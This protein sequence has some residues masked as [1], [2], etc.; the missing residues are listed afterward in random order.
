MRRAT[1]FNRMFPSKRPMVVPGSNTP[2]EN[3]FLHK[4]ANSLVQKV[5]PSLTSEPGYTSPAES[6]APSP[7]LSATPALRRASRLARAGQFEKA[8]EALPPAAETPNLS[9]G[10]RHAALLSLYRDHLI[11]QARKV[12]FKQAEEADF[13][14]IK[15]IGSVPEFTKIPT[16]VDEA[17]AKLPTIT[18]DALLV[19]VETHTSFSQPTSSVELFER[20]RGLGKLPAQ[21]LSALATSIISSSSKL[22]AHSQVSLAKKVLLSMAKEPVV[23]PDADTFNAV[24][25]VCATNVEH[26]LQTIIETIREMQH[27]G[28]A[29]TMETVATLVS[30]AEKLPVSK[31]KGL[32]FAEI[33]K[34]YTGV[35]TAHAAE[36]A[37][38][39]IIVSLAQLGFV[40]GQTNTSREMLALLSGDKKELSDNELWEQLL[41]AVPKYGLDVASLDSVFVKIPFPVRVSR[42]TFDQVYA[43]AATTLDKASFVYFCLWRIHDDRS[44]IE[45]LLT[46]LLDT[47]AVQ[48]KENGED[49]NVRQAAV[50]LASFYMKQVMRKGPQKQYLSIEPSSAAVNTILWALSDSRQTVIAWRLIDAAKKTGVAV[51]SAAIVNFLY[52]CIKRK[53]SVGVVA[54]LKMLKNSKEGFPRFSVQFKSRVQELIA[55]KE[56]AAFF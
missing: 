36:P 23:A 11:D 14:G 43:S 20:F 54:G 50:T 52:A 25:K 51:D 1:E 19:S 38:Q 8:V 46:S 33:L 5:F 42:K 24:L 48:S 34:A 45:D 15:G 18:L 12:D 47:I 29:G 53:D 31:T 6:P 56:Y 4:Y 3:W 17:V 44:G 26:N 40:V 30:I 39:K 32:F 7:V 37:C 55:P 9:E 35:I 2:Q 27:L 13:N 49:A 10:V 21:D 41:L 28:I 22:P 16:K